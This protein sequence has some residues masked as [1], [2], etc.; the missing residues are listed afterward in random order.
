ML[1]DGVDP[2]LPTTKRGKQGSAITFK[3]AFWLATGGGG[4]ILDLSIGQ[5]KEGFLFDAI[6]IDTRA[7]ACT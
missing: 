4:E 5:L 2:K 1:N 6:V 3:E 7:G